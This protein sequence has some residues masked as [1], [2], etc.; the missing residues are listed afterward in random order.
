M[1]I[2]YRA[3]QVSSGTESDRRC[4]NPARLWAER[5]L[6]TFP[7]DLRTYRI[8]IVAVTGT[9]GTPRTIAAY[10]SQYPLMQVFHWLQNGSGWIC[11]K[12]YSTDR[13]GWAGIDIEGYFI[14]E[15]NLQ[16]WKS[17][18]SWWFWHYQRLLKL[19]SP[20]WFD[21]PEYPENTMNIPFNQHEVP[22]D[23]N[24]VRF[25]FIHFVF[26][27]TFLSALPSFFPPP[28][29]I[30]AKYWMTLF[31]LTVFPAPDSPLK[32]P[33]ALFSVFSL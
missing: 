19:G 2:V 20:G 16:I 15:R 25:F 4:D 7:A 28:A 11:P 1:I 26:S 30:L 5:W 18:H 27:M 8:S 32:R 12:M 21:L 3:V 22:R 9:R 13:K 6:L 29:A 23:N 10:K 14:Q 17:C 24:S 31:V 33:N